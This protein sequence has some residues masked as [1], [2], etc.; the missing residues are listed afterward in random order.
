[1]HA[2][3]YPCLSSVCHKPILSQ[4]NIMIVAFAIS[5]A[6]TEG[7]KTT[8]CRLVDELDVSFSSQSPPST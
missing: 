8:L 3:C 6:P 2:S 4:D 7:Y 5:L 1:M